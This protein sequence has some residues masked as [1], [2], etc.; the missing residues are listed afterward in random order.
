MLRGRQFPLEKPA[1]QLLPATGKAML[2]TVVSHV[3]WI[4]NSEDDDDWTQQL[5]ESATRWM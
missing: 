4:S 1:T 5:L 2:P 3:R